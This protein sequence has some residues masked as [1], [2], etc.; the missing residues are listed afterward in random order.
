[1]EKRLDEILDL[2]DRLFEDGIPKEDWEMISP[3][4]VFYYREIPWLGRG[5]K[6][7]LIITAAF[8]MGMAY[9]KI[10]R[11]RIDALAKGKE[12]GKK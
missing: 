4:F 1:V 9:E 10:R 11:E 5:K 2:A 8:F 12:G 3:A 7:A 6:A